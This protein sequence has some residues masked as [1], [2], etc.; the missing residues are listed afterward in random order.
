MTGSSYRHL[1]LAQKAELA[2]QA[3]GCS[4]PDDAAPFRGA[5]L[6]VLP[7]LLWATG[8]L[9]AVALYLVM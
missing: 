4:V 8:G 1:D 3:F 9:F 2:G 7:T 5:H 6:R